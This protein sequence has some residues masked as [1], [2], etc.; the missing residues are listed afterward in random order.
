MGGRGSC[1]AARDRRRPIPSDR[2]FGIIE[3]RQNMSAH[4]NR[5]RPVHGVMHFP[6]QPTVV[7]CTV[8]TKHRKNWLA[9]DAVHSKLVEIWLTS[10]SW[11]MGR[12]VIMP[13]HI[14]FFAG[15]T[16]SEVPF[17]NWVRYWKSQFSKSHNHPG[18]KWQ[19]QHWDTRL[20]TKESYGEK[21]EY[22]RFN[23]VRHG[24]VE[25]PSNWPYQGEIFRW[26]WD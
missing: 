6:N 7:F 14:H 10:T 24:L 13:N 26:G 19:S 17:D 16:E 4:S 18:Q 21:W 11:V 1:R 3:V 8:C 12:Y 25:E 2:Y 20:R 22:V 9:N 23:P 15:A 5:Q